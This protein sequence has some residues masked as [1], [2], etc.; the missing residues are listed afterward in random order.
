MPEM[1]K[2]YTP[3]HMHD[4][5][6]NP[7]LLRFVRRVTDRLPGK[8]K[9]ISTE[10]PE[11]WGFACIF[12]DELEKAEREKALDLLNRMKTR[13]KYPY[14]EMKEMYGPADGTFDAVLDK[15]AVL[16]MLEYDYGDRYT[17]DGPIPGTT[18]EKEDRHYWVPLFVPGSAE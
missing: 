10:D 11:Y 6:P 13:K 3:A 14:A 2:K 9:G 5:N 17:K 8:L 18:Y 4:P 7:K 15:L 16:G 12:E 1:S